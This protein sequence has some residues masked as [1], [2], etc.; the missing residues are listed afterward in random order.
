MTTI[1]QLLDRIKWD[2]N[3][4]PEQFAVHYLDRIKNKLIE[5]RY[6][7]ILKIEPGN[8]VIKKNNEETRIPLHRIKRVTKSGF[9]FWKRD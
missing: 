1:K 5:V 6:N 3:F 4:K 9:T 2:E 8:I 7:D